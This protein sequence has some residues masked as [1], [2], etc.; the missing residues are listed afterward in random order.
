MET[1]GIQSLKERE[2]KPAKL[3]GR[4]GNGGVQKYKFFP[5]KDEGDPEFGGQRSRAGKGERKVFLLILCGFFLFASS[6]C[7]MFFINPTQFLPYAHGSSK[8]FIVFSSDGR[9][10]MDIAINAVIAANKGL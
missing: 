4:R 7:S 1:Y 10:G 6:Y 3:G 9:S 2:E 8:S 5:A